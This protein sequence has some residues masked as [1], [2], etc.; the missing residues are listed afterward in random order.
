MILENSKSRVTQNW[1][2]AMNYLSLLVTP[3]DASSNTW[4]PNQKQPLTN[5][6]PVT[7][8]E[9]ESL[10]AIFSFEIE[11]P[12]K[13]PLFSGAALE[14]KSIM[15]MYMDAKID[16]QSIKLILNSGSAG[17]IITKQLINQLSCQVNQAASSRIITADE[18][19]KTLIGEI[20]NLLIEINGITVPIKLVE[21]LSQTKEYRTTFLDKKEYIPIDDIWKRALQQLGGYSHDKHELWRMVYVKTEGITTSELLKIKNNLLSLL[22]PEYVQTFDV[23]GNIKDNPKEFHEH[24]Q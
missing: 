4:E 24:Y 18:T 7:V 12:T 3:E 2:S 14:K 15:A 21:K 10:A 22:E 17:S 8:M 1:K 23:F 9:N 6:L 16:G 13:T 5:I 19:T 20:D 11:E